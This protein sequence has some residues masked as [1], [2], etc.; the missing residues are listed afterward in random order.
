[1]QSGFRVDLQALR[2]VAVL[3]VLFYHADMLLPGGYLGGHLE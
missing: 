1:M 2:G 3:L